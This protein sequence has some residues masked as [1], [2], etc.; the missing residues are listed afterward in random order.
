MVVGKIRTWKELKKGVL[1][2]TVYTGLYFEIKG[3]PIVVSKLSHGLRVIPL[4][5]QVGFQFITDVE[6]KVSI[7]DDFFSA[8]EKML[9]ADMEFQNWEVDFATIMLKS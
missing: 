1:G 2:Q 3:E 7:P 6:R 8:A 4:L 5:D 9:K